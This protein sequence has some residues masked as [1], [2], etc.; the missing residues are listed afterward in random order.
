MYVHHPNGIIIII[1][2][3]W[4]SKRLLLMTSQRCNIFFFVVIMQNTHI[5]LFIVC[6]LNWIAVSWM[7]CGYEF[8]IF[9]PLNNYLKIDFYTISTKTDISVW[10][11]YSW[12]QFIAIKNWVPYSKTYDIHIFWC[13]SFCHNIRVTKNNMLLLS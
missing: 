12:L 11:V 7:N 3:R 1:I 10:K 4:W 13:A 5:H 6:S 2:I 9:I 8:N